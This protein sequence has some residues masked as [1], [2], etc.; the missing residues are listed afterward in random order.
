MKLLVIIVTYNAMQ[1]AKRCFDSLKASKIAND[2]FVV[3][4]GSS[5]GTQDYIKNNY[6]TV[7]F[8]QSETN[9]GFGKANNI[10]LQYALDNH[11]DYVY[12]L[13]QDAWIMPDTFEKLVKVQRENPV[14][15][16]LSPMQLQGNEKNFDKNFRNLALY[17]PLNDVF[18]IDDLYFDDLKDVYEV[19]F[20]M[21]AHWLISID[22]LKKVGGF[23]PTFRHYGEDDNYIQRTKYY[24]FK[25]G[26]V[27]NANAI[28]DRADRVI[29]K[30][31]Q[32][33]F[34]Y[35][36]WLVKMSN[37]LNPNKHFKYFIIRDTISKVKKYRSIVPIKYCCIL[38]KEYKQII[39]NE[40]FSIHN[41]GA[42]LNIKKEA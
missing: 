7:I 4:N 35:K 9:L 1:W 22:C 29:S 19:N 16:I 17:R 32:M 12:L 40:L 15:G 11:Y 31:Q 41:Q 27:P 14:F 24:N 25:I 3:D 23:S 26:V 39:E 34:D 10:G 42:F 30:K 2:V 38:L 5:D 21:A 36:Q 33:Y 28:H 8:K 37:P 6:P 13:N 20:V 18:P